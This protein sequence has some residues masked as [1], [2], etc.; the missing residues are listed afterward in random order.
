MILMITTTPI[1]TCT[2]L[3]D[4]RC[5]SRPTASRPI[6]TVS[7]PTPPDKHTTPEKHTRRRRNTHDAGETHTTL[8]KHTRCRRDTHDAGETHTMP[9]RYTRRRRNTHDAGET[10]TTLEKHTR[11]RRDTH[12]A[13]ETHTM[14]ERYTRRRRNTHDAGETHTMPEKHTRRCRIP[15]HLTINP[16]FHLFLEHSEANEVIDRSRKEKLLISTNSEVFRS[17]T[18][19]P[20]L[21]PSTA[22]CSPPVNAFRCLVSRCFLLQVVPSF[23]AMSSWRLLLGRP[24]DLFPLPG[25]HEPYGIDLKPHTLRYAVLSSESYRV[26]LCRHRLLYTSL[27]GQGKMYPSV[28]RDKM[29]PSV[30]RVRCIPRW[31]G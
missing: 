23:F 5:H 4:S 16:V 3:P 7:R 26:D 29:Y 14:P 19:S 27:G 10:H 30:A 21:C 24:L 18:F 8:E 17:F 9:E 20:R 11:C 22:G 1:L 31:P 15:C 13:G 25:C 12:D 28:A 2:E 6:S